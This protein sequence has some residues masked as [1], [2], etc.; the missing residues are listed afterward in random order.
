MYGEGVVEAMMPLRTSH[1]SKII[2]IIFEMM[3][4]N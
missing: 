2:T 3:M 4:I 1:T